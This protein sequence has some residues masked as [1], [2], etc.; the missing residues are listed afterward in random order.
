M[1]TTNITIRANGKC[2]PAVQFKDGF[3]MTTC[4]CPNSKNGRLVAQAVK[5]ADGH[6]KAN[7]GK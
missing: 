2:H 4:K 7:C 3:I 6:E 1:E 5:I